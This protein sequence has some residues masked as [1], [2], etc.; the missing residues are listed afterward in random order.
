MFFKF[1]FD[2]KAGK[3][4]HLIVQIELPE[5]VLEEIFRL[6]VI[7]EA[8]RGSIE[9]TSLPGPDVMGDRRSREL[10]KGRNQLQQ[11]LQ[12]QQQQHQQQRQQRIDEDGEEGSKQ[13]K[14]AEE[15]E[16]VETLLVWDFFH[17]SF[18]PAFLQLAFQPLIS[19]Q[20]GFSIGVW[21]P[22]GLN[23]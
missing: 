9:G 8:R 21:Q 20:T 1:S 15:P 12:Q 10:L 17:L 22:S 6:G 13:R 23:Y 5:N 19:E 16:N 4:F 3:K 18:L 11:Q 2:D 14:V 7:N